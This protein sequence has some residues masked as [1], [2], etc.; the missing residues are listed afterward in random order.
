MTQEIEQTCYTL[1]A[2]P[3]LDKVDFEKGREQD[4]QALGYILPANTLLH[5]R[6]PDVRNGKAKLRLI[7][8]DSAVEKTITLTT[9]WQTVSTTVDTVP[10][11]DTL[12]TAQPG[13][14][15][16]I[17]QQPSAT[18][19]LPCW[20]K[21][22]SEETFFLNW[23][24]NK[25][26]YALV[27]LDVITLLLPYADRDNAMNAGLAALH[28]FYTHVFSSY[29]EWAGLSDTPSSPLDKS[30]ANRYFIRADKHGVGA[31]YYLPWWCAQTSS[32]VGEG[33][34]DNVA[35]Q[36]VILHEIAHG[37]QGKFMQDPDLPLGEVWNNIYAA[38]Y[39]Q[40]T[41]SQNNV[42]YTGGWLYDYGQQ[43]TQELQLIKHI[44][45]HDP[46]STWKLRPR[47]Q[48]LMLMLLKAGTKAF[49]AFNQHYR[50]LANSENFQAAEHH[51]VDMLAQ[52][53][54]TT[55]GYDVTP[56][57]DLCGLTPDTF[58]RE[59]IAARAA[60]PLWPL[61]DL[62]PQN[63][64]ESARQQ[65]G[66][67]S[68]VW[69]VDNSELA[70]LHK[71][72][73]L[74]LTLAIDHPE[75][76]YGRTMTL[77]DNCG[78]QY[79]L[80]VND[81]TLTLS[82]IPV[83]VYHLDLPQ[84]RSQKYRTDTHYLIIREGQ[85]AVTVNF[86]AQNDASDRNVSLNFLGLS[87][88]LFAH[89]TVDYENHQLVLNIMSTTPHS[90]FANQVYGSVTILSATGE[91][92]FEQKMNG[93]GV[94]TGKVVIPFSEHDHLYV[95]HAE[96]GRLKA[97]PGYLPLVAREKYQLL[98]IDNNGLYNFLLNNN[99]ADDLQAIF[100]QCAQQIRSQPS[101]RAQE[102]SES[103]N[104]L[105]LMLSHIDEP[106][107]STLLNDYADVLP[108]DNSEPG[109]LT[110]KH[111]TL[112]MKGQESREFCQVV[113]DNQLKSMTIATRAGQPHA[114]YNATYASITVKDENGSVL[115]SRPYEGV[116]HVLA[117][118]ETIALQEGM[119]LEIFHDE[120]FRSSARNETSQRAITLKKH[121]AWRVVKEGLEVCS[122][123][124]S[125]P[126]GD[127]KA[128]DAQDAA[129]LYGDQFTWT[130]LG[131]ADLCFATLEM[132][133]GSNQ[134]T[135]STRPIVPHPAF[136][137]TYATV[138][139]YNT[140]GTVVYRQSIRGA[141][142]LGD[143]IDT[144]PLAEGYTIEVFHAEA[145]PRSTIANP[146]NNTTWRQPY[147][148]TWQVTARGLQR[149]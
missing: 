10:F 54:A 60:K 99:P 105:W 80:E 1:Q 43:P 128:P 116:T 39:Q 23:E 122:A 73:S 146:Q 92:R 109:E 133:I 117:D 71:T 118:S 107:R 26:S 19:P 48:F 17:Y 81:N 97:S 139:V 7:G 113:I 86:T 130:F 46:V 87:D 78:T 28:R 6:Q 49:S 74:A 15:T 111:I 50:E 18:K 42:L 129:E 100:R 20:K 114:Y 36:W 68:F 65:L 120:P 137:T 84:G 69:L 148:V 89:L 14:F 55:A 2:A 101:L 64:W 95:Y 131:D 142:Q 149:L 11:I 31:A 58:T 57:V 140:R 83:G 123:T 94:T 79:A 110:G 72:G 102:N 93:T 145:G 106:E 121:N 61:Y 138:D 127:D 12:Y 45:N 141:S 108:L 27:D 59:H 135:F 77:R 4:R 24:K 76:I 34:L 38:F 88:H 8:N 37:Y 16:V 25:S 51:L 40:L 22:E 62:L 103:K 85:N 98:R 126:A 29:N 144:A 119:T 35:T 125:A 13:E 53:I 75:Q 52:A 115:Y 112:N 56:F 96:P 66:L 30:V 70:K 33:W 124:P 47:L 21:G 3:W 136:S 143:Y 82:D 134:L 132:D 90:Y 67:D 5:I 91:K 41:L 32:T 9:S 63:E 44:K 104:D 147:T